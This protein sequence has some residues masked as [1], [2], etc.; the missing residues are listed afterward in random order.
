MFLLLFLLSAG[1]KL[2]FQ[3]LIFYSIAIKLIQNILPHLS[4]Y[5][6]KT[7]TKQLQNQIPHM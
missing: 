3:I 5:S 2:V 1:S 6:L 4:P 7:I